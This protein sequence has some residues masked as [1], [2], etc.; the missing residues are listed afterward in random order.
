LR[1]RFQVASVS[2]DS[3]NLEAARVELVR[4]IAQAPRFVEAHIALATTYYRLKRKIDGDRE[5]ALARKLTADQEEK[6]R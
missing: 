6:A 1:A 5:K 2:L 3:G 4:I